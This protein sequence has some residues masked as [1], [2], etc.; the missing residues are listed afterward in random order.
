MYL[1]AICLRHLESNLPDPTADAICLR[2]LCQWIRHHRG[3]TCDSRL[4]ITI[5][6]LKCLKGQLQATTFP[7][8]RKLALWAAFTLALNG[9][10]RVSEYT[11]PPL[12]SPHRSLLLSDLHLAS[13]I[14]LTISLKTNQTGPPQIITIPIISHFYLPGEGHVCIPSHPMLPPNLS[15]LY[16]PG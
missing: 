1:A 4:P 13:V 15:T 9:C 10:L 8:D 12:Y 14:T 5:P 16:A 6:I 2:Y 3:Y 7:P 11:E